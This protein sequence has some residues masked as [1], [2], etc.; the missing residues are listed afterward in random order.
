[1]NSCLPHIYLINGKFLVFD[2]NH[3]IALRSKRIVG[4]LVGCPS[5]SSQQIIISS[6]PYQISQ[7]AANL[8]HEHKLATFLRLVNH[9]ETSMEQ[10]VTNY[11]ASLL[12]LQ[13]NARRNHFE[14][15]KIELRRRNIEANE[16][17][18]GTIDESKVKMII[19]ATPTES[20]SNNY[21]EEISD[22]EVRFVLDS[23]LD[24]KRKA[25]YR[26]LYQRGYYITAGAK[27]GCDFLAYPGDPVLYHAKFA[28]R[29]VPELNGC[30]DVSRTDISELNALHRLCHTANKIVL[31]VVILHD[32]SDDRVDSVEYWSIKTK[33]YLSP[34]SRS[35]LVK[36][37]I[38]SFNSHD[39]IPPYHDHSQFIRR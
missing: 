11:K 9:E 34:E 38:D 16:E 13:E 10:N 20:P 6:L 35:A 15:R 5:G 3:A 26:D 25:V 17:R 22:S 37:P 36:Y 2:K 8:V 30:I 29:I 28:L 21:P 7:Y 18:I 4:Q 14:R 24:D 12:S 19:Q 1:M 23:L 33:E 27:F 39:R 31:F 32:K